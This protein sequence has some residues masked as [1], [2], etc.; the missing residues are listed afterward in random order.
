MLAI[1]IERT[2]S[3][4]RIL[5]LYL[6]QIYLG[7]D[8]TCGAASNR[9]FKKSLNELS[10]PEVSFLASLPKA[11]S[12][13]N[14]ENYNLAL[15]RRNWVLER[16]FVNEYIDEI[17]SWNIKALQLKPLNQNNLKFES[18]YYLEEIRKHI[19][20]IYGEDYLYNGGL[21]VRSSLIP[22]QIIADNALKSGHLLAIRGIW[23]RGALNNNTTL[24]GIRII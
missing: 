17:E 6:N 23:Y 10:I 21:S 3:K 8:R 11:P 19:L 18:D 20:S 16:M 9:Y 5:E 7:A 13:Y 22:T 4:E 12:R 15:A 24:N 14:P 2:L 1:K